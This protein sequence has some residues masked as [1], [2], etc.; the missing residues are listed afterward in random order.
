MFQPNVSLTEKNIHDTCAFR[1]LCSSRL[2]VVSTFVFQFYLDTLHTVCL[3][4][5]QATKKS[6]FPMLLFLDKHVSRSRFIL[7]E[8]KQDLEWSTYYYSMYLNSI[9]WILTDFNHLIHLINHQKDRLIF[10]IPL[11]L[12]FKKYINL[13]SKVQLEFLSSWDPNGPRYPGGHRSPEDQR[14]QE[15]LKGPRVQ[16]GLSNFCQYPRFC[17]LELRLP[18]KKG[19]VLTNTFL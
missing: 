17:I 7:K 10:S 6:I 8:R 2:S 1:S 13:I 5:K 18:M 19:S 11:L 3:V 14:V 9:A 15:G 12:Q 4:T 16:Q